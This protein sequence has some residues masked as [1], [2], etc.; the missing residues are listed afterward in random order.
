MPYLK[1]PVTKPTGHEPLT[2]LIKKLPSGAPW[3][4]KVPIV[5]ERDYDESLGRPPRGPPSSSVKTLPHHVGPAT[6]IAEGYDINW[7]ARHLP[8]LVSIGEEAGRR[9]A[10]ESFEKRFVGSTAGIKSAPSLAFADQALQMKL[11]QLEAYK[12]DMYFKGLTV[13]QMAVDPVYQ[14]LETAVRAAERL[15]ESMFGRSDAMQAAAAQMGFG[16]VSGFTPGRDVPSA[17]AA[18]TEPDMLVAV[19]ILP[20][21]A[22][23]A[24]A[25]G[26]G[27]ADV[28]AHVTSMN[29]TAAGQLRTNPVFLPALIHTIAAIRDPRIYL[30]KTDAEEVV[31]GLHAM[32]PHVPEISLYRG[33]TLTDQGRDLAVSAGRELYK[34]NETIDKQIATLPTHKRAEIEGKNSALREVFGTVLHGHTRETLES[35]YSTLGGLLGF[36]GAGALALAGGTAGL[37]L[38][39]PLTVAGLLAGAATGLGAARIH[40]AVTGAEAST[41][42]V[43]EMLNRAIRASEERGLPALPAPSRERTEL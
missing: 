36:A 16:G 6:P 17:P 20:A 9:R 12:R 5:D 3:Y 39:P 37:M 2:S 7:N 29:L 27:A 18:K 40:A 23:G 28:P 35:M 38:A 33:S 15:K 25:P 10:A 34:L 43:P 14:S 32:F 19:P 41:A 1:D 42:P 22:G 21:A 8:D 4:H 13:E 26:G 31:R 30:S 11:D 24:G